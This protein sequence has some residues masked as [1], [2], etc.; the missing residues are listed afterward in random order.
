[1]CCLIGIR[2]ENGAVPVHVP[3]RH[4]LKLLNMYLL[5]FRYQL[6]GTCF[7][8]L[9]HRI[10]AIDEAYDD[11]IVL[12]ASAGNQERN[13]DGHFY[14]PVEGGLPGKSPIGVGAITLDT[15]EAV[16]T[17]RFTWDSCFGSNVDIWAPGAAGLDALSLWTTPTPANPESD[18]FGGTSC[19]SPYAAGIV[20]MMKAVNPTLSKDDLETILQETANA[21]PDARMTTGYV[22]AFASVQ[23][24]LLSPGG[25]AP[26]LDDCEPNDFSDFY[27]IV[28][29]E[30]YCANLSSDD[31]EDGYYFYIDDM[32]PVS[33]Q[34]EQLVMGDYTATIS[35][36]GI[37]DQPLPF[38]GELNPGGYYIR[39]EPSPDINTCFYELEVSIGDP[40]IIAP[41][42]FE[43]NNTLTTSAELSFPSSLVGDTWA[44]EDINFHI[45]GD[46][47]YFEQELPE[48]PDLLHTDWLTIWIEPDDRGHRSGFNLF[49][50]SHGG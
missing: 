37:S 19:A 7:L 23:E 45:R 26:A 15:K 47:D 40:T 22:N 38:D 6:D 21:S 33:V 4:L 3:A 42:R 16:R 18:D 46:A 41:D 1:M 48:L 2:M 17:P 10:F 28:S 49:L 27:T 9:I 11:G 13:L 50:K 20:A 14:H 32:R 29:D 34:R 5:I 36:F 39:F 31:T 25:I 8:H 24:A 43:R 30:E 44:V 12:L 35:G